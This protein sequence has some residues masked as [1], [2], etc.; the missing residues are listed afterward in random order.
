VTASAPRPP[1]A[2]AAPPGP[3]ASARPVIQHG[4]TERF[5]V[6]DSRPPHYQPRL[7]ARVRVHFVDARAGVDTWQDSYYLAPVSSAGPDWGSADVASGGN[8][9]QLATEPAAGASFDEVPAALLSARDHK[10]WASSLADHLY[11]NVV[12]ELPACPALKMTAEPGMT[13]G[14]F[15]ARVALAA[16]ERRDAAVEALRDKY[17]SKLTAL[18]DRARRAMQKV[19][20]EKAQATDSTVSTALA[21][22]GSLLGA[23]F[24]GGRRGSAISKARTAARSASRTSKERTDVALAEAEA[25]SIR[26]QIEALNAELET[27]VARLESEWDPAAIP[28]EAR[29]VK[30]R[31]SDI[32]VE[33]MALVWVA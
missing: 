14:E 29:A 30:P 32:A 13:D 22:G 24:G 23:L 7:G 19:E 20:R 31:K 12:L 11:R 3:A 8:D 2:A 6:T 4:V 9:P 5:V 28:V 15:R 17:G 1:G 10:R 18:E 21:V 25:Q 27:E 16:R 33:D 26:D